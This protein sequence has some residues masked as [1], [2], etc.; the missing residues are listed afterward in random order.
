M[1][2]GKQ[3]ILNDEIVAPGTRGG[4]RCEV[5]VI[6]SGTRYKVMDEV[7]YAGMYY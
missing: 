1:S 5:F 4:D 7:L 2:N 3:P 6:S